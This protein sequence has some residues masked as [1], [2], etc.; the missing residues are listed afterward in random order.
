VRQISSKILILLI[1]IQLLWIILHI[2]PHILPT[3]MLIIHI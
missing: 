1:K 2:C 3:M